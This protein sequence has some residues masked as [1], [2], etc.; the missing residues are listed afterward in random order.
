MRIAFAAIATA[1]A[2]AFSAPAGAATIHEGDLAGGSFSGSWGAPTALGAGVTEVTGTGSQHAF[3]FFTF[4]L[5]SGAQTLTFD[6][7]APEGI[8]Y[9]Y[10]AGGTIKTSATPFRWGWD[11]ATAG[12]FQLGYRERDDQVTLALGPDFAGT[13]HVGLYFTHGANISYRVSSDAAL[14]APGVVPLPATGLLL[15]TAL[16]GTALATRRRRACGPKRA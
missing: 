16:G 12:V 5:P 14:P 13:L 9:S 4:T 3:D 10:S 7:R 2:L 11:G 8:G 6:F 15:L 1:A